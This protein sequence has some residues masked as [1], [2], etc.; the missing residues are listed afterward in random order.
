MTVK[1][2]NFVEVEKVKNLSDEERIKFIYEDKFVL[3]HKAKNVLEKIEELMS[4]DD[5]VRPPFFLLVGPPN[6][7]K[8]ALV[9]YFC[10][11]HEPYEDPEGIKVPVIYLLAPHKPDVGTFYDSIL[12]KVDLAFRKSDTLSTKFIKIKHYLKEFGVKLVVIDEIH[13]VLA[14]SKIKQRE[15]WNA[16]KNLANELKRPLVL[17]GTKD[18]LTATEVDYQISSRLTIQLLPAWTFDDNYLSFLRAYEKTL[19]LKKPSNLAEQNDL[20]LKILE[21]SEGYLGEIVAIL[22]ELAILA[23]RTGKERIDV[24]LFKELDWIPPSKRREIHHVNL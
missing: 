15:F 24:S 1:K 5:L 14:G 22:K 13:N 23:I 10:K 12:E 20:A 17:V 18:A 21:Y 11:T 4:I 8:T 6:N 2:L 19:P 9:T 16:L 7:G 3:Y